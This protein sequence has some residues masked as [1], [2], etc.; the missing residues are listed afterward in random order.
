MQCQNISLEKK[1]RIYLKI[2]HQNG[3]KI[4]SIPKIIPK[5]DDFR[6]EIGISS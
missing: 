3:E 2:H 1:N 4:F 5:I 6:L